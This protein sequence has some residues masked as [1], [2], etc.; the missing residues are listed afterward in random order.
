MTKE[1]LI[2]FE[3]EIADLYR[4][5]KIRA[6]IHLSAGN[7]DQLL[8]IFQ[9]VSRDDWVFST[10]RSHY[11]ALLHGVDP[12]WLK[13]R[14][15]AGES[16]SIMCPERKFYASAIVGGICPIALGVSAAGQKAWCFVGDMTAEGGAF[17]EAYQYAV[18]HKLPITF[19][20]EDN[21]ISTTTPTEEAWGRL[22]QRER[23]EYCSQPPGG[24]YRWPPRLMYYRYV[25]G[26]P[27][28]GIGTRVEF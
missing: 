11:H 27:H 18:N 17:Q 5:G 10:W 2:A 3:D 15:L 13:E 25:L 6:P 1:E 9:E 12:G 22:W 16:I 28:Q 8:E 14:I 20:V 26:R 7:E 21:G 23:A 4:A 19:V 24:V